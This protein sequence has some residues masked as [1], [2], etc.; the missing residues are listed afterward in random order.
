MTKRTWVYIDG[1]AYEKGLEPTSDAPLIMPDINP[2]QS[3]ID[4]SMIQS[5]SQHR[6]HLRAHGCQEI[7]NETKQHLSYYDRLPKV[8]APQQLHES[9]RSQ[10]DRMSHKEFRAA[11]KRDIDNAKWNSRKD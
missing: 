9:I 1:V 4:G 8:A 11:L 5:R 7:G 2:Y 6:E 10:I 3:M